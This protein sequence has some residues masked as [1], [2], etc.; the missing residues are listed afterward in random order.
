MKIK[1]LN[2]LLFITSL[3]GYL[4]WGK[5]NKQFLF[6]AKIEIVSKL[7]NDPTSV[8]HVFTV[9]PPCRTN[10]IVSYSVSKESK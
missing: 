9:L 1:I 7:F 4:E 5:E 6:Q 10:T 2:V 3:L 8:I